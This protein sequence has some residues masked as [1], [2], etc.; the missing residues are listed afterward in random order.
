MISLIQLTWKLWKE[1]ENDCEGGTEC[2][3]NEEWEKI[4]KFL[5]NM[6]TSSLFYHHRRHIISFHLALSFIIIIV[7]IIK[8]AVLICEAGT[9]TFFFCCSLRQ[10]GMRIILYWCIVICMRNL[11]A[12]LSELF[13][14]YQTFAIPQSELCEYASI[15]VLYCDHWCLICNSRKCESKLY[16]C[17]LMLYTSTHT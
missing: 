12:W 11:H 4:G 17:A 15:G 9:T 8:F 1:N 2:V 6:Y 5:L 10:P 7:F 16:Q 13:K 14:I 3:A